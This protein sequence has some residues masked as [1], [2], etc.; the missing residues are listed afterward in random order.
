MNVRKFCVIPGVALQ[1][2]LTGMNIGILNMNSC[3]CSTINQDNTNYSFL[4]Y[5][6][7]TRKFLLT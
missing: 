4:I 5:K 6:L 1:R 2:R 7:C 3:N